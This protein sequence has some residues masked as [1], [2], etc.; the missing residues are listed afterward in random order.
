MV[1]RLK[2]ALTRVHS[3]KPI[4][5]DVDIAQN[6]AFRADAD[7]LEEVL[8][9]LMDNAYKWAKSRVLVTAT[10]ENGVVTLTVDD[11]GSGVAE[12][13]RNGILAAGVR[14]DEQSP[15]NGLGSG[16]IDRSRR[17]S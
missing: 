10:E 15:G 7:E 5:V 4:S 3:D 9:N 6:V 12:D 17:S 13:R 1:E 11:D 16:L 2:R 14:L 8:G